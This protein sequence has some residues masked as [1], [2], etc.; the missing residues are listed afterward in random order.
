MRKAEF[1]LFDATFLSFFLSTCDS[2]GYEQSEVLDA[3]RPSAKSDAV[4]D[5]KPR[6]QAGDSA[7][8]KTCE[9]ENKDWEQKDLAADAT[10]DTDQGKTG[11]QNRSQLNRAWYTPFDAPR[12]WAIEA[13]V[14]QEQADQRPREIMASNEEA[15]SAVGK[16]PK[17]AEKLA[18]QILSSQPYDAAATLVLSAA[19]RAQNKVAEAL[20]HITKCLTHSPSA[21]LF[22]ERAACQFDL[23]DVFAAIDDATAAISLNPR[24][25]SAYDLRVEFYSMIRDWD[26]ALP[27]IDAAIQEGGESC[28]R[29]QIR[30]EIRGIL[31]DNEG[32]YRDISRAVELNPTDATLRKLKAFKASMRFDTEV[33]R[34]EY[35]AV[36]DLCPDNENAYSDYAH[37]VFFCDRFE[38]ALELCK[39][40]RGTIPDVKLQ[41]LKL[42][43]QC[44]FYLR[45]YHEALGMLSD[46]VR[47]DA[48]D[49]FL[50]M[51][52]GECY[53]RLDRPVEAM[54]DLK[55]CFGEYSDVRHVRLLIGACLLRLNRLKEAV[56]EFSF[57]IENSGVPE[58]R[59]LAYAGR[60]MAYQ[61]LGRD[62]EAALDLAAQ[63]A[64]ATD[65]NWYW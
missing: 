27:D 41:F 40:Y 47:Q 22:C 36:L 43:G 33:A 30:A 20:K 25:V 64:I 12:A 17:R 23:G 15:A 59:A 45:R 46:A 62:Q 58:I 44:L 49:E 18:R 16:D 35:K 53:L 34:S 6:P 63:K 39:R 13:S 24:Y 21:E 38:E 4:S 10:D 19:L 11:A 26:A 14:Q 57:A 42:H 29:L 50:L 5:P 60:S 7:R 3:C 65:V 9:N 56:A 8:D 61:L 51:E 1:R 52:R 55:K 32:A 28:E 48:S 31:D 37:A 54:N 2:G